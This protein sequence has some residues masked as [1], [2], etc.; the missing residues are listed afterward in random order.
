MTNHWNDIKNAD[1]ILI[2]GSNAAENHP[3]G[4]KYV[5]QAMEDG[6]TLV[7]VDP[8]YTRTSAKADIYAQVRPG[9]D[10]AF[11]GGMVK[12]ILDNNLWHDDYVKSHTNA[13][14]LIN[15]DFEGPADLDGVYS[16]LDREGRVYDKT[17]W[18][19]QTDADGI[20]LKDETLQDPNSVFQLLKKQYERYTP[21]LVSATTGTDVETLNKVYEAYASTGA[22][23]R[24]GTMMYAMGWTQHTYGT[25]VIRTGALLQLLLGN[26]GRAGGG[27]N[28]LRGES[29]VQGSTDHCILFHILP[30]YLKPPIA[31]DITLEDHLKRATPTTNDPKSANW[32]QNYPKYYVSLLKAWYMDNATAENEF[33]YQWLPKLDG[34]Y[35]WLALFDAMARGDIKG[36]VAWGQNPVVGGANANLVRDALANLDWLVAVNLWDLETP[37]FWNRPGTNP[38]DISTEVFLL[39]CAASFEK[40]GSITNSGRWA[41]WRWKAVEPLG[42]SMPDA[43]ITNELMKRVRALYEAEGGPNANAITKLY[44]NYGDGEVDTH[45]VAKEINGWFTDDVYDDDGNLVGRKGDLVPSFGVLR[46][47]GSTCSANWLYSGSYTEA[48]NMMARRDNKDYHPAGIGLYSK[49]SWCWPVNRRIIYNRASCDSSGQPYDPDR[50]VVWWKGPEAKWDTANGADVPDGGW[51]PE[52]KY[53]FI[54]K[55][56]G[57]G[58][59]FGPGL[60]DGPFPEHYEPWESVIDNPFS[61]QQHNPV[62]F[63]PEGEKQIFTAGERAD[64]PII[65]TTYRVSEHWQSGAMTRNLPWLGELQPEM[66]VEM[67]EELGSELAIDNG[68]R[69]K[70]RSQRGEVD[71]VAIVTKRFKPYQVGGEVVHVVGLPWHWG[72]KGLKTGSS[73]NLLTPSVGDANTAIPETKAFLCRVDKV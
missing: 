44:W 23:D 6:A 21:E 68:E 57:H 33:G 67:S 24:V 38:A 13:T 56:D 3:I 69:V 63:L 70:V 73:A 47:D 62:F 58:H 4:F 35:S 31:S 12:Y 71:A 34:N 48:G 54:M 11:L 30:G 27:V 14:F 2:M 50:Y 1:A 28:A 46:A 59:V 9:S 60:R 40:E 8:R 55:S 25:Q 51:A 20:P 37:N 64:F 26:I 36:F 45:F 32:W 39:P 52:D 42:D 22:P 41:Q 43:W 5:T 65:G 53:A 10:I 72:Y 18:A 29:N 16:G 66:F 61:S 7:N 17:T 19:Y 15:P 49:W